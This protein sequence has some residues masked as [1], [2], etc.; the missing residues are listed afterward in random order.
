MLNH[1]SPAV[2][3]RERKKQQTRSALVA[4]ALELFDRQGYEHTT[5]RE[6]T[7][8]VEVSERTFFRYFAGKEDLVLAPV[9]AATALFLDELTRA[10][11]A[12]PPIPAMHGA[13]HRALARL[14]DEWPCVDGKSQYA[15]TVQLIESTPTLL[16]AQLA[17]MQR[18]NERVV[19]VLAER[20]GVDPRTDPRPRIVAVVFGGVVGVA[21]HAWKGS[22]E[23]TELID[24]IDRHIAALPSA[25]SDTW[26]AAH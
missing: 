3:L 19:R 6:I 21:T 4:A 22:G 7:D 24:D 15:F 14:Q 23:I 20:Y 2:G 9:V 13:I 5:I 17:Q 25:L 12:E 10:P 16:S 18:D 26:P 1:V 8:Q 11:A